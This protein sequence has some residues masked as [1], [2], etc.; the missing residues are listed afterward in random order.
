VKAA[1][2]LR[3]GEGSSDLLTFTFTYE[4]SP[5]L[6]TLCDEAKALGYGKR[7]MRLKARYTLHN[8]ERMGLVGD[9]EFF[10]ATNRREHFREAFDSHTRRIPHVKDTP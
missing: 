5:L 9:L 7:R 6:D 3:L 8:D 1:Q 10:P 2:A 4:V